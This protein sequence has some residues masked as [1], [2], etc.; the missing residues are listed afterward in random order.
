MDKTKEMAKL[1][2]PTKALEVGTQLKDIQ[3]KLDRKADGTNTHW[4][5]AIPVT[6]TVYTANGNILNVTEGQVI[7]FGNRSIY[8]TCDM[9]QAQIDSGS[10]TLMNPESVH[11]M[12]VHKEVE[13]IKTSPYKILKPRNVVAERLA[14]LPTPKRDSSADSNSSVWATEKL[15]EWETE[16]IMSDSD[17]KPVNDQIECPPTNPKV[18]T[19]TRAKSKSV[20]T[21]VVEPTAKI[22]EEE[23]CKGDGD[24]GMFGGDAPLK[25]PSSN[26]VSAQQPPQKKKTAPVRQRRTKPTLLDRRNAPKEMKKEL[27]DIIAE[28]AQAASIIAVDTPG[29]EFDQMM[30]HPSM[31]ASLDFTTIVQ[32]G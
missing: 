25:R 2:N 14:L 11:A 23:A 16:P 12:Y 17:T 31:P 21:Q 30:N 18:E 8:L 20:S 22:A 9:L 3:S 13:M 1:K 26:D 5:G 32:S 15:R 6:T 7:S 24:K 27:N 28:A 19:K 29:M 10:L 4:T